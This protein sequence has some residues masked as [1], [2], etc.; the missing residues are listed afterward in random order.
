M[1][2][3]RSDWAF[4]PDAVYDLN[5][6]N[7]SFLKL[8]FIHRELG[9]KEWYLCLAL[10]LPELSGIDPHSSTLDFE[11]KTKISYEMIDN[12]WYYFREVA[13]V[14]QD[15]GDSTAFG[16]HRGSFALYWAFFNNIDVALLLIRQQGKTVAV[17]E[18]LVYL[19]R[20]LRGARTILMTRGSDLRVETISKM[21]Q[22]RDEL[23]KYLWKHSKDD[24][25]NTE[26]F[27]YVARDTKLITCIAQNSAEAAL[28][29]GRGLTTPRLF[30]DETAFTR[31]IRIMLPAAL[32]AGTTA[33]RNA[34]AAGIPYGN[35][36]T[37][38]PGKRDEPDG[39]FVY[40]MFHGGYFWDEKLV[41]IPSRQELI[42]FINRNS[43]GDRTL[44][45][46]PFTHRQLG[47][48]DHE[49][50]KAMANA[51]GTYEEKLRDY[52]LQWTA[53]SLMSPLTVDE[54][55]TIRKSLEVPTH[56]E[57]CKGNYIIKWY[58]PEH[59]IA[60]RLKVKHIIG[61]DTS[62]AVGRDAISFV[63]I[64]S[65]TLETACTCVVNESN[66]V[67]YANWLADVM[68]RYTDTILVIER[69]SSAPTMID[70]LLLKLPAKGIDPCRRLFNGIV[71]KR[72]DGDDDLTTW[73]RM[74]RPG[75]DSFYDIYRKHFGFVTTG[76]LRDN[77]YSDTLKNAVKIAGKNLR[78]KTLGNEL[79]ALVIKNDRIDHKASGHDDCVIAWL[80]ACWFMFYGRRLDFYG[81]SNKILM[82]RQW[83]HAEGGDFDEADLIREEEEQRAIAAEIDVLCSNIASTRSPYLKTTLERQLRIKLS[84]L[85][86][87]TSQ[88]STITELQEL[89]RNEKIK[90]R[91]LS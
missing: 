75:S 19:K 79:L 25:D 77:L 41:D 4:Y 55:E 12:F 17:A 83:I 82:K 39:K 61:L 22:I 73:L 8:A 84:Q 58:Y 42:D 33:R 31:F 35:V 66:L 69:K 6:S 36:F 74:R 50:Y 76:A 34:E 80:M 88:A 86:L 85:R 16:I 38:T 14:P 32:G 48:T 81:V 59:E 57:I 70:T 60:E 72:D 54:A 20:T 78:D 45:H 11:T 47:M 5:T 13:R 56:L 29:A 26:S 23:P 21:K 30:S 52:G 64:N 67:I 28:S 49:L 90:T 89:I 37:T 53:G 44:L 87:D 68:I 51:G 91:Y 24:A 9:V 2:L 62:D 1:I 40:D 65:E 10:T 27:T 63:M 18:L 71:Q 46:A 7:E 43:S 3:R 15:G